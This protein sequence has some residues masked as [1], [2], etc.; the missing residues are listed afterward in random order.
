[1]TLTLLSGLVLM[2][3]TGLLCL[4]VSFSLDTKRFLESNLVLMNTPPLDWFGDTWPEIV[5]K[6]TPPGYF[7]TVI[8]GNSTLSNLYGQPQFD[9]Y[10]MFAVRYNRPMAVP[11][12]GAVFYSGVPAGPGPG[13]L[14]LKQ[15]WWR[16]SFNAETFKK[17][18]RLKMVSVGS[19]H[20]L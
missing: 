15:S 6:V 17:M 13:E 10:N 14:A 1:M 20:V 3:L 5:N 16:Q 9:F 19:K 2:S 12:S 11:E 7:E 8:F 4:F 18:P